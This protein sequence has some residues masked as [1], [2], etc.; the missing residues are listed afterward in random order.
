MQHHD[1][2]PRK[3]EPLPSDPGARKRNEE[4]RRGDQKALHEA[5]VGHGGVHGHAPAEGSQ[6]ALSEQPGRA[7]VR[8]EPGPRSV[9]ERG[10]GRPKVPGQK[11]G[12]RLRGRK[13]N[14][15][16]P[17]EGRRPEELKRQARDDGAEAP[18]RPKRPRDKVRRGPKAL[19]QGQP[20]GEGEI[21][22][23]PK[24]DRRAA[25]VHEKEPQGQHLEQARDGHEKEGR[26]VLADPPALRDPRG[27][28]QRELENSR[29]P[30]RESRQDSVP[31]EQDSGRER[32]PE[33]GARVHDDDGAKVEA[34][35]PRVHEVAPGRQEV[36]RVL[37]K[38][39]Q[40]N[41]G[42]H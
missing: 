12:V 3:A 39:V 26:A 15:R 17:G 37:P 25:K 34:R 8:L 38:R 28:V 24:P 22:S 21:Q 4:V 23:P 9:H 16:V 30:G 36:A 20:P 41:E 14:G 10:R 42:S 19:G 29:G 40:A 27:P 11:A 31:I 18:G 2:S 1:A 13:R 6:P 33:G 5:R 7:G 35:V 32:D